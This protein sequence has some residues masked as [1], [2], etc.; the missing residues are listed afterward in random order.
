[1]IDQKLLQILVCP[2]DKTAVKLAEQDVINDLNNA[3][4]SGSL[5]NRAGVSITNEIEGGLIRADGKYL[6]PIRDGI[7]IM[8]IDEAIELQEF[9]AG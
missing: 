4:N 1:M 3:I 2:E 8:L 9:I 5:K 6:Y 7:P